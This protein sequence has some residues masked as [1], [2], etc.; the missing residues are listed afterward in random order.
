MPKIEEAGCE[1]E[2]PLRPDL[3]PNL[4]LHGQKLAFLL[5]LIPPLG[6]LSENCPMAYIKRA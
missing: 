3:P 5:G 1:I 6:R 4:R 2:R